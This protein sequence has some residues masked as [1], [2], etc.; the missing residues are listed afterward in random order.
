MMKRKLTV[1]SMPAL[2]LA[3]A[4]SA[5]ATT[6]TFSEGSSNADIPENYGS[7]IAADQPGFVTTDGTGATPDIGLTWA[8]AGGYDEATSNVL[9]W[10]QSSN[11]NLTHIGNGVLQLDMDLS[12]HSFSG[13]PAAPTVDF[14]VPAGIQLVLHGLGIGNALDQNEDPYDW[15]I[16]VIKLSDM[17]TVFSY[18]TAMMVAGDSEQVDINFTGDPGEDYRILFDDSAAGI[19]RTGIDNLSF[20]QIPEPASLALMS[21]GGLLLARRNR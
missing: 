9:E 5:Q 3:I 16:S 10:H 1:I 19:E 15:T 17:S 21:L 11:F 7:N 14:S 6:M 18:T 4:G 13:L 8:P 12:G 20:S 2:L